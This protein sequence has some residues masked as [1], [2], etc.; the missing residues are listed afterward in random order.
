[1]EK[2]KQGGLSKFLDILKCCMLGL[3]VTLVGIVIFALILKFADV[4]SKGIGYINDVIK[5]ISI[6]II[7]FCLNKKSEGKLIINSFFAG[8]VY[9]IL[10][11]VVFSILNGR[12]SLNLTILYDLLFSVIVALIVAIMVNLMSRKS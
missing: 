10:S 5:A 4:S 8:I 9:S 1:M 7:V 2:I 11:L 3:V 12:F 6:F